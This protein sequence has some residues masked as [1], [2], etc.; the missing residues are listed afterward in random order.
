MHINKEV[1]YM[2]STVNNMWNNW[3]ENRQIEELNKL[4]I[5]QINQHII[6]MIILNI[7]LKTIIIMIIIIIIIIILILISW[8]K[9]NNNNQLLILY[10][11]LL[12]L[13][14]KSM[15]HNIITQINSINIQIKTLILQVSHKQLYK[16]IIVQILIKKTRTTYNN[17]NKTPIRRKTR[18]NN[19]M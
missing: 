6:I 18:F 10:K 1:S 16:D 15:K 5:Y 13:M 11:I 2:L 4:E 7:R 19:L 3:Q 9:I 14:I 12:I 8:I 17:P